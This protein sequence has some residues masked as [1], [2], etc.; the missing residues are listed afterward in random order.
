MPEYRSEIEKCRKCRGPADAFVEYQQSSQGHR[1]RVIHR[2]RCQHG[3]TGLVV[4]GP[5]ARC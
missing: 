5:G 4:H 2:I 1:W 3:C